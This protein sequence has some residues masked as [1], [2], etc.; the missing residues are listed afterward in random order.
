MVAKLSRTD[1][2]T[3]SRPKHACYPGTIL[4]AVRVGS[5]RRGEGRCYYSYICFL[6][7]P[8][9]PAECTFTTHT[10]GATTSSAGQR[11][12]TYSLTHN[13]YSRGVFVCAR[14]TAFFTSAAPTTMLANLGSTALLTSTAPTIVAAYSCTTAFLAVAVSLTVL[15]DLGPTALFTGTAPTTV[16]ADLGPTALL[17][18]TAHTTMAAYSSSN[19][20]LALR[21]HTIVLTD[22]GPTTFLALRPPPAVLAPAGLFNV[23]S[24]LIEIDSRSN[25][26]PVRIMMRLSNPN[27]T[28]S[29]IGV[30]YLS[31]RNSFEVDHRFWLTSI[32]L[33]PRHHKQT[34]ILPI[35]L[36]LSELRGDKANP[37]C[38]DTNACATVGHDKIRCT[39]IYLQI[40]K[41]LTLRRYRRYLR[42]SYECER[43]NN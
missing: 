21:A 2:G 39:R 24:L 6:K 27:R 11:N 34:P 26:C 10:G 29:H 33:L 25:A 13:P 16:L 7:L 43:L 41:Y 5:A 35:S 4:L 12:N 18:S 15:A 1:T 31:G 17:T 36:S 3:F 42:N 14:G 38:C 8:S 20:F 22:L 19:T 28:V 40:K 37:K 30:D 9:S 32:F 23:Y